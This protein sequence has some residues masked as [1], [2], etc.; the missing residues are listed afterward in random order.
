MPE[1]NIFSLFTLHDNLEQSQFEQTDSSQ[2]MSQSSQLAI[3]GES[4][5]SE[6]ISPPVS[7]ISS[8][9]RT[10]LAII[11]ALQQ[12]NED[13]RKE[14]SEMR[15]VAVHLRRRILYLETD[16]GVLSHKLQTHSKRYNHLR[17]LYF[18]QETTT[19][20][21]NL[22]HLDELQL[23]MPSLSSRP[24]RRFST[25]ALHLRGGHQD[26][27]HWYEKSAVKLSEPVLSPEPGIPIDTPQLPL[28]PWRF[29]IVECSKRHR[30]NMGLALL[31]IWGGHPNDPS[32]E[33][34][35]TQD[36][37]SCALGCL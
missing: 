27:D 26:F 12:Q 32:C 19:R 8:K 17:K 3:S 11:T 6:P 21:Q 30:K 29:P 33:P 31:N 20:Y 18:Q 28:D 36:D 37:C 4:D 16:L 15:A 14:N 7:K 2:E 22:P 35:D 9:R 5:W 34:E 23:P 1:T 10:R 25:S 24:I 13:L